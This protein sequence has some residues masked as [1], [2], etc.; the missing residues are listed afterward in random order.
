MR[1]FIC[2][3]H[4]RSVYGHLG[5][6]EYDYEGTHNQL[7]DEPGKNRM[8]YWSEITA[9]LCH[10]PRTYVLGA[11]NS[12]FCFCSIFLAFCFLLFSFLFFF[13]FFFFFFFFENFNRFER[14][15]FCYLPKDS[16]MCNWKI[17]KVWQVRK[18]ERQN[19]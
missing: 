17:K 10:P 5:N 1:V 19:T 12:H 16:G 4:W 13:S 3:F 6:L 18:S 7:R 11:E 14:F 8:N 9:K 15:R 2:Q